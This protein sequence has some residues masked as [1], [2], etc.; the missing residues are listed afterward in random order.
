MNRQPDC[1]L[2]ES[3]LETITAQGLEVLPQLFALLL[4]A[5]MQAERQKYLNAAPYEC[6]PERVDYANGYRTAPPVPSDAPPLFLAIADDDIL[7]AP[8]SAARLYEAWHKTGRSGEL[9]I[10]SGG[11]RFWHEDAKSCFRYMAPSLQALAVCPRLSCTRRKR[12]MKEAHNEHLESCLGVKTQKM[13]IGEVLVLTW[14]SL[15]TYGVATGLDLVGQ[16]SRSLTGIALLYLLSV[17]SRPPWNVF[18]KVSYT[19]LA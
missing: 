1:T 13:G 18:L 4:N 16:L 12:G 17:S 8:R 7:V 14:P 19:T 9:H 3:L 5:A 6:T 15:L 11:A 2:S 10:F